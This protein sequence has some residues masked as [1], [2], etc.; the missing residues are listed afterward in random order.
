MASLETFPHSD[1]KREA[2]AEG[3]YN[4]EEIAELKEPMASLINLLKEKIEAGEYDV[5]ISDDASGRIPTLIVKKVIDSIR[6]EDGNIKTFFIAAG[7]DRRI[8]E[9]AIKEFA[10]KTLSKTHRALVVTELIYS[11]KSIRRLAKV[12]DDGGFN[13]FDIAAVMASQDF[14]DGKKDVEMVEKGHEIFCGEIGDPIPNIYDSRFITGVARRRRVEAEG[15]YVTGAH[16]YLAEDLFEYTGDDRVE[17]KKSVSKAR[18]DV[19]LLSD[20][21]LSEVWK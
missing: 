8:D 5:L 11:G 9:R 1:K 17:V 14:F 3:R 15:S 16:P 21:I 10:G 12:L 18:Q 4:F 6:S 13:D 2:K 7:K 19:K 20:E